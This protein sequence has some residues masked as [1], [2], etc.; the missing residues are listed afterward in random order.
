MARALEEV[1]VSLDEVRDAKKGGPPNAC[2]GS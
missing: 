1:K 2:W